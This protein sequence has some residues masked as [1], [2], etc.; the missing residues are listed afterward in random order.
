MRRICENGDVRRDDGRGLPPK[1]LA[2]AEIIFE[3][4]GTEF[5]NLHMIVEEREILS[6]LKVQGDLKYGLLL[7][8]FREFHR[9]A[10]HH[11]ADPA[12]LLLRQ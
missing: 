8:Y 5:G 11:R 10:D 4:V 2:G 6:L 9:V 3:T 12:L 7:Q 1:R